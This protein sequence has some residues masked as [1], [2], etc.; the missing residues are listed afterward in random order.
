MVFERKFSNIAE[1]KNE[2]LYKKLKA[3]IYTTK[4]SDKVFPAIR[5]APEFYRISENF[6]KRS[7]RVSF[8]FSS[9]ETS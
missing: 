5:K 1:L 3:D 7:S 2:P 9:P 8:C 6:C 4:A